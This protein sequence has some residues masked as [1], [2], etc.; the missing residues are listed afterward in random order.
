MSKSQSRRRVWSVETLEGRVVPSGGVAGHPAAAQVMALV[1][2][3]AAGVHIYAPPGHAY[4]GAVASFD[5]TLQGLR[6]GRYTATIDWGDG[7]HTTLGR[8]AASRAFANHDLVVS[9]THVYRQAGDHAVHVTISQRGRAVMA[10]SSMASV[11]A[12]PTAVPHATPLVS[13]VPVATGPATSPPSANAPGTD[14]YLGYQF[15]DLSS[16]GAVAGFNGSLDDYRAGLYSATINWGD[17]TPTQAGAVVRGASNSV[18]PPPVNLLVSGLHTYLVGGDYTL[19]VTVMRGGQVLFSD[20]GTNPV[21]PP[22]GY[23]PYIFGT[24]KT[25]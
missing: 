14:L 11:G 15:A 9:G 4:S 22:L 7:H 10:V 25:K 5:G 17:G 19:T 18:D 6:A 2:G 3:T 13:P 16:G 8:F 24:I 1:N 12:L 21:G 23:N 20:S